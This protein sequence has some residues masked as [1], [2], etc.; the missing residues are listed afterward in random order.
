MSRRAATGEFSMLAAVSLFA[1]LSSGVATARARTTPCR[2][3]FRAAEVA[4]QDAFDW[5]DPSL[6]GWNRS[7]G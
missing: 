4:I 7:L 5:F 6:I 1:I 3:P 2:V